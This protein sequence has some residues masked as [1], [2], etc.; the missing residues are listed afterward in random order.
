MSAIGFGS[1]PLGDLYARLDE[2]TAIAT[3]RAAVAAGV[4]LFDTSP[5]YGNGLAEHRVGSG[6]RGVPRD[7]Y[8]LSTKVG[9][10]MDPL[11]SGGT[12]VARG[13][14][15]PGFAGGLPHKAII[16]YSYD[17]AMRAFEQSLLRL[18]AERIDVVLIHDVDVWT[19]GEDAIEARFKEAM[20]GRLCGAREAAPGGRRQGDRRR[21]QRGAHVRA[22]RARRRF[23]HH[24]AR[25]A[26]Y[27]ARTRCA[28]RLHG[29]RRC[30]KASA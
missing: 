9:R 3:V 25:R 26:L 24:A 12:A 8:V 22:L 16:D 7:A 21:S 1:A 4:T 20:E 28:R 6:L 19:H 15:A 30:K 27:L 13:A 29:A 17:G 2:D 23:R 18:A 14:A 5:H 11:R 10:L